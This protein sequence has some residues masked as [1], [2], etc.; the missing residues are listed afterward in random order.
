VTGLVLLA[1]VLLQAPQQPVHVTASLS[2]DRIAVGTT[3]TLRIEVEAR[4]VGS[5]DIANPMLPVGLEVVG[6]SDYSQIRVARPGN[7]VRST[8]RELLLLASAPGVYE[9]PEVHVSAG[10]RRYRSDAVRLTVTGAGPRMPAGV[11]GGA[12]LESTTLLLHAEPDS[13]F[14]GEQ[15]ILSAVAT[16]AEESRFRQTRPASFE[17]PAASG[18]WVQD[19]PDPVTVTLRVRDGRSVES[20]TYRRAYF[21]LTAGAMRVPPAHLHYELRRGFLQPPETRR[22]SSDSVTLVVRPLPSAGRPP[23]FNGA[24]GRFDLHASVAPARVAVGEAALLTVQLSGVGN[25]RALPEPRLPRIDGMEIFAPTQEATVSVESDVVGGTARF[26]WMIV[27]ERARRFIIPPFE[28]SYFDPELRAYVTLRTDSLTIEALPVVAGAPGDTALRTLRL[29]S[30]LPPAAWAHTRWFAALQAVPLLLVGFIVGVRRRRERPP[31]PAQ[32]A[33]RIRRQLAALRGRGSAALPDVERLLRE[34]VRSVA[35]VDGDDGAAA[36]RAAG[37]HAAATE[38]AAIIAEVRHARYAPG[39]S[40]D[41]EPII[42]RAQRLV[43]E[44]APRRRGWRRQQATACIAG[45]LLLAAGLALRAHEAQGAAAIVEDADVVFADAL[46]RHATGDVVSAANMFLHYAR[47]RPADATGWYNHGVAAHQAGDHGR[48]VWAWLRAARV[49]PRA[50]DIRHNL[51]VTAGPDALAAVLPPDRLAA[52]ERAAAAAVAWWLLLAG[53]G[54]S[55]LRRRRVRWIAAPAA[56][57]LLVLGTTAAA[58]AAAP[59]RVTPLGQGSAAFAGPSIHDE[60]I[61]ELPPGTVVR[62]SARRDGWLLVRLGD[63]RPAWVPRAA[64]AAP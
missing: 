59:L 11:E 36:L 31:G 49:E 55:L 2:A 40:V 15:V 5:V 13:V 18:F 44:L 25:V 42:E 63:G 43:A 47:L 22:V 1:A 57:A 33:T 35:G 16:F 12:P 30:G 23:S 4:G 17:P 53:L 9:I 19:L 8:R 32:H 10:G 54:A 21:P 38:F 62:V 27:P 3:T 46:A 45:A 56:V 14:V 28:Y 41:A 48:A 24:V 7:T 34:A 50:D 52:G 64:V 51:A 39:A 37:R 58:V 6:S 60:R 20:Q 61:A 29:Q 26:R